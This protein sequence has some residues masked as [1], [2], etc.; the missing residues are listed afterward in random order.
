MPHFTHLPSM[1]TEGRSWN[2]TEADEPKTKP[3]K[4]G[5]LTI[6]KSGLPAGLASSDQM[7][8]SNRS[9]STHVQRHA[10]NSPYLVG[11]LSHR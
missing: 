6:D 5:M 11:S 2:S 4:P 8:H 3:E 1:I 7:P 10:P 9:S